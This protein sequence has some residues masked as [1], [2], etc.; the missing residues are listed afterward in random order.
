MPSKTK[1][2]TK[3]SKSEPSVS[4]ETSAPAVLVA[5]APEPVTAP[6]A[7]AP[8]AIQASVPS[9]AP[10]APV[11]SEAMKTVS[12]IVADYLEGMKPHE[13]ITLK[14]LAQLVCDK[15]G[16]QPTV[17]T[18]VISLLTKNW[19]GITIEKG[20]FGGIYKGGREVEAKKPDERP[21]CGH[22]HQIIR[23]K[24]TGPRKSKKKKEGENA[25]AQTGDGAPVPTSNE[26]AGAA[27]S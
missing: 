16:I 13:K 11:G 5:P 1:K 19:P 23:A 8:V 24:P 14:S 4:T 9:L 2:K 3:S 15:T 10:V 22:C 27:A 21:R 7:P 26:Q 18:P 20:R 17:A 25:T 6:V 12:S